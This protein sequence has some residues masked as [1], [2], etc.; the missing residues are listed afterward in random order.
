MTTAICIVA[1]MAGDT[2][3]DL[4]TGYIV[5]VTPLYQQ[6]GELIGSVAAG[7]AIAG[8]LYLPIHLSTPIMVGGL[9][10]L[11]VE[12]RKFKSEERRQE[13]I[14]DGVL[15]SSGMIAGEGLA[16]SLCSIRHQFRYEGY[17]GQLGRRCIL[18]Y[19]CSYY[20]SLYVR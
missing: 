14:N 8:V 11:W 16:G 2:S 17:P 1:A 3:Q 15:Y 4:K 18:P 5:G 9:I 6:I 12:K 20:D 19:S 10:R 13:V 7:L